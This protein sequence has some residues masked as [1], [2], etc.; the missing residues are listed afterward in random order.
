MRFSVIFVLCLFACGTEPEMLAQK[1]EVPKKVVTVQQP[2]ALK[3]KASHPEIV[4]QKNSVKSKS[5]KKV[6]ATTFVKKRKNFEAHKPK[7]TKMHA[8]VK[9]KPAPRVIKKESVAKKSF[10]REVAYQEHMKTMKKLYAF[11]PRSFDA[12]L[13]EDN[14]SEFQDPT[15]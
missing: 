3:A 8:S 7:K 14:H 4:K 10:S 12:A 1:S 9:Q 5:S 6:I 11:K 13:N 2:F 15:L